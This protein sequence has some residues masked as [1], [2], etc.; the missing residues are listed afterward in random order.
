MS[1]ESNVINSFRKIKE[2]M[3]ELKNEILNIAES[4]EKVDFLVDELRNENKTQNKVISKVKG[5]T[6]DFVAAK[7]GKKFHIPACPYAKNIKPKYQV[8]F[9]TRNSALNK[10]YKPCN[11]VR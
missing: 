8:K 2:E 3:L 4:Q 1:F 9:K 6:K 11:C 7:A 10:G 5:R